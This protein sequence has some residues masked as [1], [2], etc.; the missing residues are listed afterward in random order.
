MKTDK[1][2]HDQIASDCKQQ[3]L[4]E[5]KLNFYECAMHF[6]DTNEVL[7]VVKVLENAKSADKK[8][9]GEID[10]TAAGLKSIWVRHHLHM[11]DINLKS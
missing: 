2:R 11:Q 8:T 4:M 9:Q 7:E 6:F 5:D 3:R 1:P 10:K